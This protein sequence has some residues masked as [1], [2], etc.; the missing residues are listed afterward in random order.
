M[1]NIVMLICSMS[2]ILISVLRLKTTEQQYMGLGEGKGV[3]QC[4]ALGM[5]I[6]KAFCADRQ[7]EG[8]V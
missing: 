7:V 4:D 6:E 2:S 3:T 5:G 1:F 8:K